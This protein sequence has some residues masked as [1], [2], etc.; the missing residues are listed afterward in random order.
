MIEWLALG[1]QGGV[2]L[3]KFGI[4][5][6]LGVTSWQWAV[7]CVAFLTFAGSLWFI[8]FVTFI[9]KKSDELF[10]AFPYFDQLERWLKAKGIKVPW[11]DDDDDSDNDNDKNN[12]KTNE[13]ISND[14]KTLKKQKSFKVKQLALEQMQCDP[15]KEVMTYR[16]CF[17]FV[18][19]CFIF[20]FHFYVCVF[21]YD[22]ITVKHF[23]FCAI[24]Q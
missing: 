13:N 19:F 6:L 12:D 4:G 8:C 21:L 9:L 1:S 14:P 5:L 16:F 24:S 23:F 17:G 18:F 2:F 20:F 10:F 22:Y 11:D 15:L 7:R 3:S